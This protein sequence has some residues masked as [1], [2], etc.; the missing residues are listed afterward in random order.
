MMFIPKCA[1]LIS[2]LLMV[3]FTFATN[4]KPKRCPDITVVRIEN[5]TKAIEVN[6]G[7][8]VT[9]NTSRYGTPFNWILMIGTLVAESKKQALEQSRQ[10]L[11][12]ITKNPTPQKDGENNWV[13]VYDTGKHGLKA[14]AYQTDE[15]TLPIRMIY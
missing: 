7:V 3:T 11:L 5:M 8:Y 12:T 4:Y 2:S 15:I 14:F 1:V 9:Y 6:P 13:C 10:L